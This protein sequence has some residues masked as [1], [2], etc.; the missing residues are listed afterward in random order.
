[1]ST[2]FFKIIVTSNVKQ[3]EAQI[4]FEHFDIPMMMFHW[5]WFM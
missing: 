4:L 2:I 3:Y 5:N 1:M